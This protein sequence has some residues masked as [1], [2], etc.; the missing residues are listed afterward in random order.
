[1]RSALRT[2]GLAALAL[3]FAAGCG[4]PGA[5]SV[6]GAGTEALSVG[7]EPPIGTALV[8]DHDLTLAPGDY[9]RRATGE[10]G[11]LVIEGRR[12]VTVD[13]RGVRLRGTRAGS[14]PDKGAGRGVIIRDCEDVRVLGGHLSGYRVGL[15]IENSSGVV[16][17]GLVVDPTFGPHLSG[18]TRGGLDPR[19]AGSTLERFGAAIAIVESSDVEVTNCR[20]R[21]G[22][23]GLVALRSDGCRIADNDFSYLSGFG[24]VL[25]GTTQSEVLGNR[26]DAISRTPNR[27][28]EDCG[29]TGLLLTGGSTDNLVCGN[30]ARECC[31]GGRDLEG[32]RNRWMMNDF[33]GGTAVGLQLIGGREDW[34]V[35]NRIA[36]GA[37]A[38]IEAMDTVELALCENGVESLYGSGLR[39]EGG[40]RAVISGNQLSDCDGA[41]EVTGAG[42]ALNHWIGRNSFRK[43]IQDLVLEEAAGIEF[44]KNDFDQSRPLLHLDGLTAEG[45]QKLE[46]REVWEWL[47]DADGD[48]P[49]GRSSHAELRWA[50]PQPPILLARV[51]GWSGPM[52]YVTLPQRGDA[53]GELALG[54][55]GPWDPASG[56]T[57]P[58]ASRAR[59]V[60][61]GARWKAA[62]FPWTQ[63]SDPRGD[64]D[65]WRS[66]RYEATV[67]TEVRAWNDPWGGSTSV[68]RDL[69]TNRFGLM[70]STTVEVREPGSYLLS[71]RSDDGVR[72]T[73]DGEVVLEDW[74]WHP[75]Q[76][77]T[78][79]IQLEAGSH[80]IELEYFQIDGTAVL[81]LDLEGP[82]TR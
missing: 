43:N 12:D 69:P 10:N 65:R 32:V 53:P 38:G 33:S 58:D 41:L 64:L 63:S 9:L 49:S 60:L 34:V 3:L 26:C 36:D 1:M 80:R 77:R 79:E 28:Q 11:V 5:P 13:L 57:R 39:I 67:R 55:Y 37:G 54:E 21:G 24:I 4:A 56:T 72:V 47:K 73:L 29:S 51:S 16:V 7:V 76:E 50:S 44:W 42:G 75:S 62:W 35:G 61:S 22:A 17:D 40:E 2:P 15:W 8:V 46:G 70:A 74:T 31:V 45:N 59:G 19:D 68:R 81:E 48:L 6:S 30:A 18:M 14:T 23:N 78:S 52:G 20:A 82:V 71:T 25:D 66:L 27:G